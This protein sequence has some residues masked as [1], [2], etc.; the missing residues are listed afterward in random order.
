M[1][2]HPTI[3]E[4]LINFVSAW[5]L[6]FSNFIVYFVQYCAKQTSCAS[7]RAKSL[8]YIYIITYIICHFWNGIRSQHPH[9]LNPKMSPLPIWTFL[10]MYIIY[11]LDL[12]HNV[13]KGYGTGRW[14]ISCLDQK[15][16]YF[17][18]CIFLF[19]TIEEISC[20]HGER[21]KR[22]V[23]NMSSTWGNWVN[24]G[25]LK[26]ELKFLRILRFFLR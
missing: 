20:M 11:E 1:R 4:M 19:P 10:I 21:W 7:R 6:R 5:S 25:F 14:P 23:F 3:S 2:S 15:L 24:L 16:P 12:G 18:S 9:L 22:V 26:T 17:A 8:W 13:P